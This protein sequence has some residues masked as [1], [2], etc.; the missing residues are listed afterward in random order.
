MS[1]V[2]QILPL[3]DG[4]LRRKQFDMKLELINLNV[5]NQHMIAQF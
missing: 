3:S 5:N 1:E 4:Q 2:L